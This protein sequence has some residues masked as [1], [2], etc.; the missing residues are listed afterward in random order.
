[1]LG[2]D[3]EAAGCRLVRLAAVTST[4]D[5]GRALAAS[6]ETGPLW[7]VADSQSGG[8][9][10]HG[11]IWTSPPGNLYATLLLTEP[12]PQ[13]RA[14]ELG[15]VAS[16]ALH[17]AINGCTG[18]ESPDLAL[19]WPNDVLVRGAKVAGLLLEGQTLPG[20]TAFVVTIGLGINIQSAPEDTP[21]PA[22]TLSAYAPHVTREDVF[23][24]LSNAF[25]AR[26]A[27]WRDFGFLPLRE[28]WLARA[29]GRG[30]NVTVRL[31]AGMVCGEFQGIDATGRLILLT[32]D[33]QRVID[34]G[35]LFFEARA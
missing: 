17:D 13:A 4:M 16:L 10:R 11:R 35:D 1:M 20:K 27:R 28:D 30:E 18:L 6:G 34:A 19:K 14:P 23:T 8:R 29:A 3:A 21:Y 2:K 26:F 32:S 12:C 24:A 22:T 7:I 25:A 15:F 31:P 5:E 9:G 33:G